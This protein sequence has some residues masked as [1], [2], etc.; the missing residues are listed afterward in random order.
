M[1]IRLGLEDLFPEEILEDSLI[2]KQWQRATP[3]LRNTRIQHT[4][5]QPTEAALVKFA[6]PI[7]E[8]AIKW[9]AQQGL[10][11]TGARAVLLYAF[12]GKEFDEFHRKLLLEED[13]D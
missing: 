9:A 4:L 1:K 2:T 13:K 12:S 6:G 11:V 5:N 7:A 10:K 8:E 3:E